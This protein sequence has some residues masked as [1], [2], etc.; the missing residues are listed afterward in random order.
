[1]NSA[2][3]LYFC[4]HGACS[5]IVKRRGEFI[6]DEFVAA[7]YSKSWELSTYGQGQ[8]GKNWSVLKDNGHAY[9]ATLSQQIP[10]PNGQLNNAV[11]IVKTVGGTFFWE[12]QVSV[13]DAYSIVAIE[14]VNGEVVFL[15]Q[16][17]ASIISQNMPCLEDTPPPTEGV[18]LELVMTTSN[19]SPDQW[20]NVEVTI[21]A[22]NTGDQPVTGVWAIFQKPN[23]VVYTGGNEWSATQGVFYPFGNEWWDIGTIQPG[24]SASLTVSYFV[25]TENAIT[26]WAEITGA[27]EPD[28]DSTPANGT[29]C[30][31]NE[32]D[33]AT[34]VLNNFN[35]G[36]GGNALQVFDD[37]IRLDFGNIYPN[38]AKYLVTLELFSK[39]AQPV[40]LTF[41]D[42]MGRS[43]YVLKTELKEGVNEIVM[44]VH[45]WRS[46]AYNVV[47]IGD[48]TPSY[49]RFVKVWE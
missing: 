16:D 47:A 6:G 26:P 41:Y 10:A 3:G 39:M 34:L 4:I 28:T 27:N 30:T 46:G 12:K 2:V 25:L 22:T 8:R 17:G 35:G 33:E 24:A 29:C 45:E 14:E 20:S 32:D 23:G 42:A 49:G 13:P 38:P 48:G 15:Q 7:H 40:E 5:E 18:D 11:T 36:G 1:M 9:S 37:R 31:P 44:D 43:L 21:T 19:L